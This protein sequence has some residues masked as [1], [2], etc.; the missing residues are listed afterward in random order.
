MR[1]KAWSERVGKHEIKAPHHL[2]TV[3]LPEEPA[4]SPFHEQHL[5]REREGI[6]AHHCMKSSHTKV[7]VVV[8]GLRKKLQAI[9]IFFSKKQPS[10]ETKKGARC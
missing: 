3:I 7:C 5:V 2:Y 1:G 8:L 9:Y 10:K 4:Y 6:L